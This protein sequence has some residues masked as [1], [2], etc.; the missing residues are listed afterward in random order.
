MTD[1]FTRELSLAGRSPEWRA[2]PEVIDK[3]RSSGADAGGMEFWK[4]VSRATGR[5]ELSV[6]QM[7]RAYACVMQFA[8]VLGPT[9]TDEVLRSSFSW[10]EVVGRIAD[11]EPDRALQLLLTPSLAQGVREV[12]EELR[13]VRRD[14]HLVRNVRVRGQQRRRDA[15]ELVAR[16]LITVPDRAEP[17]PRFVP[18][19]ADTPTV[20]PTLV[21][22][23]ET[24]AW[25]AVAA[26]VIIR[27]ER[28]SLFEALRQACWEAG[29]FATYWLAVPVSADRELESVTTRLAIGNLGIARFDVVADEVQATLRPARAIPDPDRRSFIVIPDRHQR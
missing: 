25:A 3:L 27:S 16:R 13:E 26:L 23:P 22:I 1:S 9:R 12:R 18:Y 15:V 20:S 8:S 21:S 29:F 2:I 24:T 6:R 4:R 17:L 7:C 14:R 19:A 10:L 11:V 28:S 5:P